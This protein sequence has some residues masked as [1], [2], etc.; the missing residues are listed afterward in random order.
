MFIVDDDAE[1][2]DALRELLVVEGHHVVCLANG[3]Q[4]IDC[5]HLSAQM[6]S[7]IIT[8]LTMPVMDGVQL[9]RAV[10]ADARYRSIPIIVLTG[11][12]DTMIPVQLD[13]PVVY[14]PDI[15]SLL[16]LIPAAV[17]AA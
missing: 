5:L 11:K 14:K 8:D 13:T 4:A 7:L 9:V 3:R 17:R 2:R 1:A 6:P 10:R 15:E 16:R 12:N